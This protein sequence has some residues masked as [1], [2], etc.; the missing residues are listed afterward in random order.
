MTYLALALGALFVAVLWRV[1][2]GYASPDQPYQYLSRMDAAV[3][4]AAAEVTFPKGGEVAP[5]YADAKVV[6]YCDQYIMWLPQSHRVLI[7]LLCILFEHATLVFGPKPW[8]RF[9]ALSLADQT[10]YL[11]GWDQSPLYLRRMAFQSLRAILC[12]AYLA[13]DEVNRQF[14]NIRPANCE[15]NA[16]VNQGAKA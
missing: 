11:D 12:M 9:T 1:F 7:R 10:R 6:A 4:R 13:D 3:F 16:I 8:R 2:G 15:A 14:G 5:S